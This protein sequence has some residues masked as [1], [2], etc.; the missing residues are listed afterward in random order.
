MQS[1]NDKI[2]KK[3]NKKKLPSAES[4]NNAKSGLS[5]CFINKS[6]HSLTT[7]APYNINKIG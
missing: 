4:V 1:E 7:P 2:T 3:Q 6:N 5:I